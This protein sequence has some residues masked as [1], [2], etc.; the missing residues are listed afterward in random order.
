MKIAASLLSFA[1]VVFASVDAYEE[2]TVDYYLDNLSDEVFDAVAQEK[3]EALSDYAVDFVW[4][5]EAEYDRNNQ[6]NTAAEMNIKCLVGD[7][8]RNEELSK[9]IIVVL[10][11]LRRNRLRKPDGSHR[12][13]EDDGSARYYYELLSSIQPTLRRRRM[14]IAVSL[15]LFATFALV[16]LAQIEEGTVDYY[17]GLSDADFDAI[18]QEKFE[19]LS[20]PEALDFESKV[21]SEFDRC[22]EDSGCTQMGII[23]LVSET[24][25]NA[26]LYKEVA[27][28]LSALGRNKLRKALDFESKVEA[29]FDR[30]IGDSGCTQMGIIGLVSETQQNAIL[31]KEVAIV[32]SALGRNKLRK[33]DDSR[34]I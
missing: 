23:G 4:K 5:V 24:Q 8:W 12:L 6:N 34:R 9:E 1:F 14:K 2:G 10:C 33:E 7:L 26:I 25:Q 15:I 11:A 16:V 29:E 27:I 21:E 31:Y 30:C 13:K 20:S 32:L 18:V 22:K 3:F 19:A 17:N 28:V